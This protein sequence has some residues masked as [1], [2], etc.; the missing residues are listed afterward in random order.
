MTPSG[1]LE[2]VAAIVADTLG[3]DAVT[4]TPSTTAADVEGWD[5]LA[6]V[7]I[8]VAIEKKFG[9]RFRTGDIATIRNVGE[10]VARIDARITDPAG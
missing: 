10:L 3:L 7:Q 5:S 2:Q 6:N 9:M 4:L 8:I 1:T